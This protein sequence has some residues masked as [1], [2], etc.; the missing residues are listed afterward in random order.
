[1]KKPKVSE[2]QF[3]SMILTEA[4]NY[5]IETTIEAR[6]LAQCLTHQYHKRYEI[7]KEQNNYQRG[8][9]FYGR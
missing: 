1:M 2:K 3:K 4:L 6:C 9:D 8:G 5:D 7:K